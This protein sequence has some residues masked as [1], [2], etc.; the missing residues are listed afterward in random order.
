M[1]ILRYLTHVPKSLHVDMKE[2][3]VLFIALVIRIICFLISEPWNTSV[4][5]E[6][7]IYGD[8]KSYLHL[9]EGISAGNLSEVLDPKRT[10]GYPI[11]IASVFSF[12]EDS[13]VALIITQILL[14]L[15]TVFFI[16]RIGAQIHQSKTVPFF[17]GLVYSLSIFAA[18]ACITV[19]SE[20]LFVFLFTFGTY[21]LIKSIHKPG[22]FR[23]ILFGLITG[24]C[25]TIRPVN[26]YYTPIIFV[27]FMIILQTPI[28]K[29]ILY[30]FVASATVFVVLLPS[31]MIN[32]HQYG[33]FKLTTIQDHN[34]FFYNVPFSIHSATGEP[35]Q[36]I[37]NRMQKKITNLGDEFLMAKE[38]RSLAINYIKE[39]PG[40][41]TKT[42][43][44]GVINM[45]I[46]IEKGAI[47]YEL[48]DLEYPSDPSIYLYGTFEG[49]SDRLDRVIRDIGQEFFLT[50]I[51]GTKLLLEYILL[52]VGTAVALR[53]KRSRLY[54]LIMIGTILYFSAAI[55]AVGYPRYKIPLIA[56]YAPIVGLGFT[57]AWDQILNRY[58]SL[59]T[60]LYN[61]GTRS[62]L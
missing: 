24:L 28:K 17:G 32:N 22:F 44:K 7:I 50:P 36:S 59:S 5:N 58:Y 43:L 25:T 9:A 46:G 60:T 29:R 34:L 62:G 20:T 33:H 10:L 12:T 49:L 57:V 31:F 39:N 1:N 3:V 37:R 53:S 6:Q 18:I 2:I 40:D 35:I 56:I 52:T 27:L 45:F 26:F 48:L 30:C 55:G 61:G 15:G 21:V 42:H 13:F 23:I 54:A 19:L 11:F 38:Q 47:L 16:M 41:Y 51:L 14:D 4:F 8:S